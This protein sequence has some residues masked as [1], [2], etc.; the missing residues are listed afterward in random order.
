VPDVVRALAAQAIDVAP[1]TPDELRDL[2][3]RDFWRDL[4]AKTGIR[5]E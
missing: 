3:R 5:V 2:M 4:G 1:A